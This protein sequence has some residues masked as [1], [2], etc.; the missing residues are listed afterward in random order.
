MADTDSDSDT[1]TNNNIQLQTI[2]NNAL[3]NIT[4]FV[5]NNIIT[6]LTSFIPS[7]T[8]TTCPGLLTKLLN[9]LI[10]IL[11]GIYVMLCNIF[12]DIFNTERFDSCYHMKGSTDC[13]LIDTETDYEISLIGNTIKHKYIPITY[14]YL[15]EVNVDLIIS[16]YLWSDDSEVLYQNVQILKYKFFVND[17]YCLNSTD[18]T[19]DF[20][21]YLLSSI[22][23]LIDFEDRSPCNLNGTPLPNIL[24]DVSL[25]VVFVFLSS[26]GTEVIYDPTDEDAEVPTGKLKSLKLVVC[27]TL[28]RQITD[29]ATAV[30]KIKSTA[31]VSV[32]TNKSPNCCD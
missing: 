15:M 4:P 28:D 29:N 18:E 21:C 9:C 7:L 10:L 20:C 11:K 16:Y 26:T 14:G 17:P 24:Q 12:G 6:P 30:E 22:P 19:T 5:K 1:D 23:E 32:I 3:N 31:K 27:T 25:K 2:F 13:A 8:S